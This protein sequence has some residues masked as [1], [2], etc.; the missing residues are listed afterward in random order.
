[1]VNMNWVGIDTGKEKFDASIWHVGQDKNIKLLPVKEFNRTEMG[2]KKLL[3]WVDEYLIQQLGHAEDPGHQFRVVTDS[4][5]RLS[6]ELCAWLLK[7][8]TSIKPSIVN[9]KLLKS[10]SRSLGLRNKTDDLDARSH[11]LYGV[12]RNPVPFQPPEKHFQ[13]LKELGRERLFLLEQKVA[14]GNRSKEI[15]NVQAVSKIHQQYLEYLGKTIKK[16]EQKMSKIVS[17]HP[18]LKED[19][20]LLMT[21]SGIG[22]I[23]ALMIVA[24]LGDLRRFESNKQLGG[25]SGLSP[26]R[27]DSGKLKGKTT[28]SRS[29]DSRIRKILYM[30]ALTASRMNN[31]LGDFYSKHLEKGKCKKSGLCAL[32]RKLLILSRTVI[33]KQ[34][35]FIP[36][37]QRQRI[38]NTVNNGLKKKCG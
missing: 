36:D 8:R 31:D 29:G 2:V 7:A 24:E 16:T 35:K 6:I 1:M 28:I 23:T 20:K 17:Q 32:M 4:T 15:E 21:I 5:G 25:Y 33:V 9:P 38:D 10:Y 22:K 18:Q 11:C 34:Q 26:K 13:S 27:H 14:S 30:P 3:E 19:V 12:E 37:F